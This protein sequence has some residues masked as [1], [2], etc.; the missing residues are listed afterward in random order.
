MTKFILSCLIL[1]I[2]GAFLY[3]IGYMIHD[4]WYGHYDRASAVGVF[5]ILMYHIEDRVRQS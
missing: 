4:L 2:T 1:L 3:A 5:I